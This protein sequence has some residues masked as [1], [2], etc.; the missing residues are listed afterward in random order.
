M[1][2]KGAFD[3]SGGYYEAAKTKVL[4]VRLDVRDL[5]RGSFRTCLDRTPC[6]PIDFLTCALSVLSSPEQPQSV[7]VAACECMLAALVEGLQ[8]PTG[9][10]QAIWSFWV[11]HPGRRGWRHASNIGSIPD[12]V[13]HQEA[14][15]ILTR[16]HGGDDHR[17]L[18]VDVLTGEGH[19]GLLTDP[20]LLTLFERASNANRARE[21][22]R[23]LEASHDG[24]GIET[25]TLLMIRDRFASS[26]V[27]G[28]RDAS[29]SVAGLLVHPDF[30]FVRVMLEDPDSEVRCSMAQALDVDH[31]GR[32]CCLGLVE[33]R[34][35]IETH[36]RVRI[37]LV[38]A[39]ASILEAIQGIEDKHPGRRRGRR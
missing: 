32:E 35:R 26:P 15:E 4:K 1:V 11:S 25:E 39:Q 21:L 12:S 13:V 29:I 38:R 31:V 7:R 2:G 8:L 17:D 34:I 22:Q 36:Y 9:A 23:L 24:R 18:A 27:P 14:I 3:T 19:R 6:M 20:F 10:V 37:A 33:G 5:G 16:E 30:D 28:V